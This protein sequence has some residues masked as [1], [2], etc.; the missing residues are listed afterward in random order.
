MWRAG[1]WGAKD[2]ERRADPGVEET[3]CFCPFYEPCFSKAFISCVLSS[4]SAKS[5]SPLEAPT[6]GGPLRKASF[7]L[8][9]TSPFA[10]HS[11][12]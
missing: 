7:L 4:P 12:F 2:L 3:K 11:A 10:P 5:Y 6:W 8:R 9:Q 1:C